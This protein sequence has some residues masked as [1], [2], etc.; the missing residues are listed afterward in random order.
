MESIKGS[1]LPGATQKDDR[2]GG[3]P[4]EREG[5]SGRGRGDGGGWQGEH[6]KGVSRNEASA[7]HV[8]GGVCTNEKPG[9]REG[10]HRTF[11]SEGT[12]QSAMPRARL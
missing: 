3:S 6:N 2:A 7:S 9:E 10:P 11:E 4:A 12:D 5:W 1:L 8:S